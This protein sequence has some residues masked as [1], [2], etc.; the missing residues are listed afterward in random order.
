MRS[1]KKYFIISFFIASLCITSVFAASIQEEIDLGK[2]INEELLKKYSLYKDTDAIN[3]LNKMGNL[4]IQNV[5][6][7]EIPYTFQILDDDSLNAFAVPGGFIYFTKRL[8]F[9]LRDSERAGVLAHEIAH[10]DKRHTIKAIEERQKRYLI[11]GIL[12]AVI[13]AN[14][15]WSDIASI[16]NNLFSLKYSRDDENEAD[17]VSVKLT[18][19]ADMDPAGTLLALRKI[20]RFEDENGFKQ[21]EIFSSHPPTQ[22]RL[23]R[24]E[25]LILDVGGNIPEENVGI[26]GLEEI[27]GNVSSISRNKVKFKTNT[28]LQIGDDVWFFNSGWDYYYENKAP[29]PAGRG[30]VIKTGNECEAIIFKADDVD[31]NKHTVVYIAND[32]VID[33][34]YGKITIDNNSKPL[35]NLKKPVYTLDRFLAKQNIWNSKS[36]T[37][38]LSNSGYL[39]ITDHINNNYFLNS[40]PNLPFSP[41]QVKS[42]I[43][44]YI[45]PYSEK[46]LGT[47]NG[48]GKNNG[49]ID[50]LSE[51]TLDKH[52]TYQVLL[53]PYDEMQSFESRIIGEAKMKSQLS[54]K[55]VNKKVLV[56]TSYNSGYTIHSIKNGFDVYEK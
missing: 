19:M 16:A 20:I 47:I 52:K 23:K 44:K 46:W 41:P 49:T 54:A 28:P 33:D 55:D 11:T 21:P 36:N 14:N 37:F 3:D 25:K 30:I 17:A 10:V 32:F 2:K 56:M 24:L 8:W 48:I 6:R 40:N 13:E 50:V 39:V 15:T 9:T 29:V 35:L 45:D 22:D 27:H 53:P 34:S 26:I 7:T 42:E 51:K 38:E 12:L 4:L 1:Y 43:V 18:H 31:I 5:K